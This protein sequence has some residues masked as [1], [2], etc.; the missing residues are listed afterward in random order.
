M[1]KKNPHIFRKWWH[2]KRRL[3]EQICE[4]AGEV[5]LLWWH[6]R[7]ITFLVYLFCFLS[8]FK[9]MVHWAKDT[10]LPHLWPHKA[11]GRCRVSGGHITTP[12][13]LCKHNENKATTSKEIQLYLTLTFNTSQEEHGFET[14][15]VTKN[16]STKTAKHIFGKV[17]IHG[18]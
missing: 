12:L 13:Y 2:V 17:K 6:A 5:D 3:N 15:S 16:M 8:F 7:W 18:D 1:E 9:C 10:H 14:F 11:F 4:I